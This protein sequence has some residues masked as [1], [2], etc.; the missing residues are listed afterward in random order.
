[1]KRLSSALL[2]MLFLL[3]AS[4]AAAE[5]T[6]P[7]PDALLEWTASLMN[8]FLASDPTA[9]KPVVPVSGWPVYCGGD[10]TCQYPTDWSVLS[11]DMVSF[12]VCDA[13][14]LACYD[15]VQTQ[16]FSQ[17][18]THDQLALF[19]LNRITGG[20][21]F[22]LVN[23]CQKNMFPQLML[24]APSGI[25]QLYFIRWQH[26]QAGMMFA[27]VNVQILAYYEGYPMGS[28]HAS[29]S[30]YSAPEGEFLDTWQSVFAPMI[31]SA[32]Y[33]IPREGA[34]EDM[35]SDGDGYPDYLDAYPTDPFR[36]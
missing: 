32:T 12:L 20:A 22:S 34:A 23:T 10:W 5:E 7:L 16:W 14:R 21:A 35:D 15:Y 4:S 9:L 25:A 18:C 27:L 31:Y 26:P 1:M 36:H 17:A 29:W 11:G 24:P 33:T 8:E 2:A 30:V 19:V 13:R 3:T 28:T 6:S